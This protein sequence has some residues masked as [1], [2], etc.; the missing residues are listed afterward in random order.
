MKIIKLEPAS[1]VKGLKMKFK[2]VIEVDIDQTR[3][4][5]EDYTSDPIE[6]IKRDLEGQCYLTVEEIEQL[7]LENYP[8]S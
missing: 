7:P 6:I 4:G 5:L 3:E 2:V 8:M 1:K